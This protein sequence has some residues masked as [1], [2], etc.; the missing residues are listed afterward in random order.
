MASAI[1]KILR[2]F[3]LLS[4]ALLLGVGHLAA[5][6]DP[7]PAM[8]KECYANQHHDPK[9]K[10]EKKHKELPCAI[11]G[12]CAGE[13]ISPCVIFELEHGLSGWHFDDHEDK[14]TE[15][16][17]YRR[18][19]GDLGSHPRI[20]FVCEGSSY[21][22]RLHFPNF[23]EEDNSVGAYKANVIYKILYRIDGGPIQNI[24]GHYVSG[25]NFTINEGD[26]FTQRLLG[27]KKIIFRLDQDA[28]T[29]K[30]DMHDMDFALQRTRQALSPL[31]KQC[32]NYAVFQPHI[33][34]Q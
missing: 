31:G 13:E 16:K 18:W 22:I 32:V 10:I 8:P 26:Q 24:D 2:T 23:S 25:G 7:M 28:L 4:T 27:A 1:R 3:L 14:F 5:F 19:F 6:A 15:E 29:Q 21:F 30:R 34:K 11:P 33:W 20:E 17:W 12:Y 9:P